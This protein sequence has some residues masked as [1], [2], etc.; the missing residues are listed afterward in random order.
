MKVTKE[1]REKLI[2]YLNNFYKK[3][4]TE[5]F[6]IFHYVRFFKLRL[7]NKL[8][9][10]N[11]ISGETG[12]LSKDTKLKGYNL[13][14]EELYN[15]FGNEFIETKSYDFDKNIVVPSISKIICSG[16]KQL[17]EVVF[18]GGNIIKATVDHKFFVLRDN[19]IVELTLKDIKRGDSLVSIK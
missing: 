10:W 3:F 19:K 15:K 8:D 5:R 2:Y 14:L 17:Y 16:K 11:A 1:D 12:C 7:K 9:A 4:P 18:E 13:S 6:T